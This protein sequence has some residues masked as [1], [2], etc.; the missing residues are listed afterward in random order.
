MTCH[1][2]IRTIEHGCN[3]ITTI[4]RYTHCKHIQ[5]GEVLL[6]LHCADALR[7]PALHTVQ[8][9]EGVEPVDALRAQRKHQHIGQVIVGRPQA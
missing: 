2:I 7:H 1:S 6:H 3:P 9:K 5:D 8:R 4:T